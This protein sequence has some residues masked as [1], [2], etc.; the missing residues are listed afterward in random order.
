[1]NAPVISKVYNMTA[2]IRII[3]L[4]PDNPEAIT[5]TASLLF[6]GF[7]EHNPNGWPDME[8]AF[9]EVEESLQEGHIS[10]IAMD[11]ENKVLGWIGGIGKYQG[12]VWEL[13]PLVVDPDYQ[14]HGIGSA[15]VQDFEKQVKERG[16][17]TIWLGADD[18]DNMTSISGIDLYPDVLG[19]LVRIRNIKGHPYEFYQKM[20]FVIVGALPDADGPGKPDIFMAKRL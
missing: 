5:E 9:R 7:R 11:K 3:D 17:T 20:G 14:R 10:R 15:L 12:H 6:N 4:R 18:E 13:H 8:A 19:H 1:V 2:D 16:G